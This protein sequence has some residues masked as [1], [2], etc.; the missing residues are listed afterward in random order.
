M[1]TTSLSEERKEYEWSRKS[2]LIVATQG[3][4]AHTDHSIAI[5]ACVVSLVRPARGGM[6]KGK[7]SEVGEVYLP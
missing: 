7:R 3:I 4:D 5:S 6:R 2:W 1:M